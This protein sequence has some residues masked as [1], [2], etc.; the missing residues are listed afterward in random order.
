V[1]LDLTIPG[2]PGG[3]EVLAEL[4]RLDPSVTGIV[5]SGYADN[6]VLAQYEGYGFAGRLPKPFNLGGLSAEVERVLQPPRRR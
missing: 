1:I 3:N 2:M 5:T 4:R 6:D